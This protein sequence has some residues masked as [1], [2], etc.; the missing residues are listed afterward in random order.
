MNSNNTLTDTIN[1]QIQ[2]NLYLMNNIYNYIN[3]IIANPGPI[4]ILFVVIIFY[5]IVFS[6][7]GGTSQTDSDGSDINSSSGP[8]MFML[9]FIIIIVVY[10]VYIFLGIN[11]VQYITDI[12]TKK[13]NINI[14]LSI[15]QSRFK[16]SVVPQLKFKPQPFNIPG[17]TYTYNDAKSLCSAYGARLAK[18]DEVED[19]YN[20]GG[21]WCNYGWS[22]D[23]MA[24]Y[25]TQQT[26]Y[27]GLQKIKGHEHDCGRPGI[28]G[29]YID[30]PETKFGVN[31]FGYKPKI[32]SD[33]EELMANTTP[34]P[35]TQQDI[36]MEKRVQY[37]QNNLNKILV[38]PFNYKSWSKI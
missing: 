30:D 17:N 38:S 1:P 25:P 33:E 15:D 5:I 35:K 6:Y 31:C 10:G 29:G 27:D 36:D 9:I 4:T 12:I 3:G 22:E 23:Q 34:Y 7:L 20:S 11:V 19:A 16:H 32:T 26:T 28:N 37:W 2:P 14:D 24:L 18:Y 13:R 21:E 8:S